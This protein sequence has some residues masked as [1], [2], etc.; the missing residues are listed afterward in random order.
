MIMK[1]DMEDI[2]KI[3]YFIFVAVSNCQNKK[4]LKLSI[5]N[6]ALTYHYKK[7]H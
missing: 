5:D 6:N 1:V 3:N 2:L 7:N 4:I